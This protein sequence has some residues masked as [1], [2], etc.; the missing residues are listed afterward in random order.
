MDKIVEKGFV[1][2]ISP[3]DGGNGVIGLLVEVVVP[4]KA[5][6]AGKDIDILVHAGAVTLSQG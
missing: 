6:A 2:S 5:D 1:R 4:A 3:I